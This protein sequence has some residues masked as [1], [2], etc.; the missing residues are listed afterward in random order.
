MGFLEGL[1][2][3]ASHVPA[4]LKGLFCSICLKAADLYDS[5]R[6]LATQVVLTLPTQIDFG[7]IP[8]PCLYRGI[9]SIEG[10]GARY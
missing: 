2:C 7:A 10:S 3:A 6:G 8:G 9:S 4:E 1:L 5:Y